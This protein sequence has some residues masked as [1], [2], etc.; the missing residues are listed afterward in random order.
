MPASRHRPLAYSALSHAVGARQ[1]EA[2]Q[3]TTAFNALCASLTGQLHP[4]FGAAATDALFVRALHLA[5]QE[6]PWVPALALESNGQCSLEAA[7]AV[8]DTLPIED[9]QAGLA[10]VLAYDIDL[11]IAFVGEDLVLPLVRRAWPAIASELKGE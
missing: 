8:A 10:A 5:G 2:N 4:L 3:L 6:F 1:P 11:L 9:L 7:A